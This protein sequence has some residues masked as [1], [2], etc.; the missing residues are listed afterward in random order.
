MNLDELYAMAYQ[1]GYRDGHKDAEE[2]RG[3][4]IVVNRDTLLEQITSVV[5]AYYG[6]P[7]SD[8]FS[9]SRKHVFVMARNMSISLTRL[10]SKMSLKLIGYHFGGRDHT[11]VIHSIN[12]LNDLKETDEDVLKEWEYLRQIVSQYV[13][14]SETV[15]VKPKELADAVRKVKRKI[16]ALKSITKPLPAEEVYT[17]PTAEYSNTGHLNLVKKYSEVG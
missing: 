2:K 7:K 4:L 1:E 17:R 11:T 5:C 14:K 8:M 10:Y 16:V 12:A 6:I 13:L 15:I 3:K 9:K